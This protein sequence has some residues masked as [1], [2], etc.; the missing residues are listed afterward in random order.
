MVGVMVELDI[1]L[2]VS[3]FGFPNLTRKP[4]KEKWNIVLTV[5]TNPAPHT[6]KRDNSDTEVR[7]T[8][9]KDGLITLLIPAISAT[10]LPATNLQNVR[11]ENCDQA[12]R[13][14]IDSTGCY[15]FQHLLNDFQ[16]LL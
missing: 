12:F 2:I 16:A 8:N 14:R 13:L 10:K 7:R 3:R 15:F 11:A 5:T 1:K 4:V 6:V 9:D